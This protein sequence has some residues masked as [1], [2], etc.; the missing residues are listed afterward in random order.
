MLSNTES[1]IV[2][3]APED[4]CQIAAPC[5]AVKFLNSLPEINT[6]P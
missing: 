1:S 4:C 5:L 2:T 6:F 3:L